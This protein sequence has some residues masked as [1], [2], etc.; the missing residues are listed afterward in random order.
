MNMNAPSPGPRITAVL[1]PTNT[2]KT[3]FAMER[4]LA[5]K[6]GMIGFPLR[7]LARENYDRVVAAKGVGKAALI[8]GEERIL[9]P[10]PAYY[11]CTVE[12]MPLDRETDFLAID[13]IQLAADHERGHI[14]TDRLLRARGQ[15]ETMFLGSEI[16]RRLVRRLVPEAEYVSRPR[17]STL[18][19]T[20]PRRLTRLPPRSA[21]V[22]FSAAGVYELAELMRR[23][24]GG[25]AV[26][27]GALSPRTR[28]AQVGMYQAGEVDY[29]VA[30]DAIGMGLNMDISH[31]A[32]A[33]LGKFDGTARRPL[34]AHEIGQI[35][36]R[37]GRYLRNG[38]FGTTNGVG[39]LDEERVAAV[40]NHEFE[41]LK[42]LYWRNADLDF[43][44][45]AAL[46]R[47]LDA[48]PPDPVL[49]RA[50]EADDQRLLAML[51]DHADVAERASGA[52]ALRLLWEVCQVP[53]FRKIISDS[54]AR[55]LARAYLHLTGSGRLP[56]D[57]VAA[58]IAAIDRVDGE[59]ETLTQRISF[60]RTW[61][62]ISHRVDWL[63]DSAHW[64]ER[65]REIEDRLSDALHDRLTQRF[66]DRRAATLARGRGAGRKAMASVT[67]DD[68]VLVEG[69]FVGRLAGFRFVPDGTAAGDDARAIRG[70][71]LSALRDIV[72]AR[73]RDCIGAA[74]RDF[75][76]DDDGGILWRGAVIARLRNSRDVLAPGI[77][78]A[79]GE[80][81]EAS[82]REALRRRLSDWLAARLGRDLAPLFALRE[83]AAQGGGA[84]RGL[85]FQLVEALGLLPR[86]PLAKLLGEIGADGRKAVTALGV[87]IGLESIFVTGLAKG[88]GRRVR[89]ILW[90]VAHDADAGE[91]AKA[92]LSCH[93]LRGIAAGAYLAQG[94]VPAGR[95]AVR[96]DVLEKLSAEARRL[97]RQG[98]FLA[99]PTLANSIGAGVED[100]P[101]VLAALDYHSIDED[102]VV[103]FA[104]PAPKHRR[105]TKAKR[106][107]RRTVAADPDS[108]FAKLRDLKLAK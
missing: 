71:A 24:Q 38:S 52:A 31:V 58:Q 21:A 86:R 14:F 70:A 15:A 108:P 93:R 64:Q 60:I 44:S 94:F 29:L 48:P 28:N 13:E 40:E 32:F 76:L 73:L 63:D 92:A 49:V 72:P 101:G 36:G 35:A 16:V 65:T 55:F 67:N 78:V 34:T 57:W 42:G 90:A 83:R 26:V 45:L 37:A 99:T 102:G 66:V 19:Y 53:D 22:V 56:T 88:R 105:R 10:N 51:T 54:H 79:A 47:S 103:T 2:G 39:A 84:V 104:A 30:T 12:S 18:A 25:V 46:R 1:G 87:R 81:L 27:L 41:P 5:H 74:D 9:P 107:R 20:G 97:A 75:D 61:T 80:L 106:P 17:F 89:R 33:A 8:T 3:H 82:S 11:L 95:I 77:E 100:L 7:L 69:E 23:R 50:P 62:Y 4:M 98:P 68:E 91:V 59:I 43:T 85:A 6:S 96:A